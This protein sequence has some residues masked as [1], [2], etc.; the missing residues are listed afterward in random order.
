VH[1]C[2]DCSLDSG[3]GCQLHLEPG[4]HI[5]T[6]IYL[7]IHPPT[8]PS[9][10]HRSLTVLVHVCLSSDVDVLD[11]SAPQYNNRLDTPLPDVPFVRN[12]SAE[13]KKLKEKEKGPWTQL[14][15]EEKIASKSAR[16][17]ANF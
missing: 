2:G 7:S 13:Q 1:W 17:K 6:V 8:H 5:L 10:I 9:T 15:K 16:A 12:L 11:C 3:G 4:L 14:T